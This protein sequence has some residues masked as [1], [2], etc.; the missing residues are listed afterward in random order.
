MANNLSS[1]TSTI[2]LKKFVE[3]FMDNIIAARTVDTQIF[4]DEVSPNT[5]DTVYVK[6]PIQA[7]SI[8]TAG[9]DLTSESPDNLISG[10]APGTVQNYITGY[11]SWTS[12]EQ[13]TQLNQLDTFLE[14]FARKM[15]TTLEQNLLAFMN[16]NAGL[17]VGTGGNAV[18]KWSDV[19][20]ANSLMEAMGVQNPS[21]WYALI[22]PFVRQNLADQQKGLFQG[23]LVTS[24]WERAMISQDFGGM[25]ALSHNA[26]PSHTNGA[27]GAGPIQIDGAS[28]E[29]GYVAVKDTMTQT[30]SLKGLTATTGTL[31]AGDQL[32]IAGVQWLNQQAK[33]GVTGADGNAR[34][35]TCSVVTGGTAD[36]SGDLD[37]TITPPM[38]IDATN[39]QYNNVTGAPADS[40]TVTV[41]S[42]STG[43]TNKPNLFYSKD[44][45]ALATVELPKLHSIDS[46]VINVEGFSIRQHKFSS[47]IANTQSVRWDLLPVFSVL[48]PM[49]AGKMYGN[50]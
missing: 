15:V 27:Y 43:S 22:D 48:Q 36:G 16:N 40:A 6:R 3:K 14:P 42:G 12:L 30:L 31:V 17:T 33:T 23:G 9:G 32:Q 38:I 8:E 20:A 37:V 13:A 35:F 18:T 34:T 5:G 24:A 46:Q 45:F 21:Q 11:T 47:G 29:V 39:P 10:R 49:F 7:N 19:A 25:Q 4:K 50:P 2:V 1:N 26:L 28:Q 41:I 44:A